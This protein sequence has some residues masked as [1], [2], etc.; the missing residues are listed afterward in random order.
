VTTTRLIEE[1]CRDAERQ[2]L[3]RIEKLARQMEEVVL[4]IGLALSAETNFDRLME[5]ILV[6]AKLLCHADAG[7]LYLRCEGEILRFAIVM[8][9]SLGL[10]LGG[11][12]GRAVSFPLL[13]L[14]DQA[15]GAPN[16]RNVATHVALTGRSI[17]IPDIYEAEGFDFSGT[18]AFDHMNGYRSVSSLTVPLKDHTGHVTGVLQLLNARDAAGSITAFDEYD[19]V[20]V[21]S[22]SSLASVVLN[23]HLLLQRQ[24]ALSKVENDILVARRIHDGFLPATLPRPAGWQIDA[25]FRPAREV[26]GDFYDAFTLAEERSLALVIADVCDKGVG[27]ALFMALTRSLIRAFSEQHDATHPRRTDADG[28][29]PDDT[30]PVSGDVHLLRAAV[31]ATNAYIVAHHLELNMFATLFMGVLEL[32][33]GS[34]VY[35][36]AGHCP[37]MVVGASGGLERRLQPTGPAIGI[38][39][40]PDFAIQH[41]RLAPGET[42]L[43]F[44]DGATD[45]RNAAGALL[46][47]ERLASL[48]SQPASSATGLLDAVESGVRNHVGDTPPYDDLTLLAVRRS[49]EQPTTRWGPKGPR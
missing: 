28:A 8:T 32:S 38:F 25:R 26:G 39:A 45:A 4:P 18:K 5:R 1:G 40:D 41:D 35:L 11:T 12:T 16:H 23:N 15:T 47:M 34:L 33:S 24:Q 7:S 2:R 20:V 42:L 13:R 49:P 48:A 27:A 31:A 22:L 43:A 30:D 37:P 10:A 19:R 6:E 17:S 14:Y 21:E 3:L 36:N 9:D 44:T 29:A 46:G